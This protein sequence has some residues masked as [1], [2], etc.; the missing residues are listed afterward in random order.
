MIEEVNLDRDK[1]MEVVAG[2]SSDIYTSERTKC[3]IFQ[4]VRS[5]SIEVA[6]ILG[7]K[8]GAVQTKSLLGCLPL[9]FG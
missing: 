5:I 3:Q 1:K 8:S 6:Y 2:L 4:D 7:Q 9:T